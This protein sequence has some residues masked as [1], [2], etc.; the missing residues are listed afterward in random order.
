[1]PLFFG[2]QDYFI[3]IKFSYI[4]KHFHYFKT[5]YFK[6]YPGEEWARMVIPCEFKVTYL[7][8]FNLCVIRIS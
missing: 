1:M 2:Q 5:V 6:K 8:K 3:F 7:N 4:D